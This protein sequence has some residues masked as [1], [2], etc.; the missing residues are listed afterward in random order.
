MKAKDTCIVTGG[1]GFIG[2][3]LSAGLCERF[4]H[5]VAI[6]NLHPQVHAKRERPR[7][8]DARVELVVADITE[9]AVWTEVLARSP[10]GVVVHLASETGTGQS[11]FAS[12][13]H[14]HVNVTG[15]AVMLDALAQATRQPDRIVLASSRAVY[16]EGAA[17]AADGSLV[18]P[19]QRSREQ[20]ER[21]QWDFAGLTHVPAAAALTQPLPVSIYGATKLAQEHM[22][23]AWANAMGTRTAILRLQNVYGPGQSLTNPYVG[24]VSL[25]CRLAREGRGIPLYEDGRM[26]RDFVY[27]D[28]VAA[29]LL[30]AVDATAASC[31]VDI[32]TGAGTTIAEAAAIVA[33]IYGAPAPQVCGKFRFGDVRHASCDP[34]AAA[35]LLGWRATVDAATG[36]KRLARWIDG[37]LGGASP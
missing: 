29:A 28:D 11:L 36:L 24:I 1:A 21:G 5:V 9:A 26:L 18:Y 33:S 37:E 15:T 16:G 32:G 30:R 14:A 12:A 4:E 20:L 23:A 7:A 10:P 34:S 17:R 8:L 3:A 19:G 27:I 35:T 31:R 13:R 25:F 22:L 2:C 6:D